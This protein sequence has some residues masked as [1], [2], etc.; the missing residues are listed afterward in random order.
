[1]KQKHILL[2]LGAFVLLGLTSCKNKDLFNKEIYDEMV[3]FK[4]MVDN[5]DRSHDWQ[6][7]K[8]SSVIV[9]AP[10]NVSRLQVLTADP[11]S[12]PKA[13]IAAEVGC[14]DGQATL[15]YSIPTITDMLYLAALASDGTHL[16][17]VPFQYDTQ[18]IDLR[19]V[20]LQN[21]GQLRT[22]SP[23]TFSYLYEATF[24]EPGDFDYNDLVLRISKHYTSDPT[25]VLLTVKVDAVGIQKQVA[26]AIQLAGFR[27]EDVT[28]VSI[29]E[30][31]IMDKNYPLPRRYINSDLQLMRGRSGQAVI[32]LFEDAHWVMNKEKE[33]DGS[34]YRRVL[35]TSKIETENYS[36]FA[37]PVTATFC[38]NF[39]SAE[40]AQKLTFDKM[41]PF[42][43]EEY[44]GG[45]WEVHT[46]AHKF[47]EVLKDIYHGQASAY[48]NHVSWCLTIPK[49]DFRY[50]I[51]NMSLG[52]YNSDTK[53][54]FGPYE[55]FA[56]WIQDHTSYLDWYLNPTIPQQLY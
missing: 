30:G 35:N 18:E 27:Y 45:L 53:A 21:S 6:L 40:L 39:K 38:I 20:A 25:L 28:S 50:P 29:L 17:V 22:I 44:N 47:D 10:D 5:M 11:Y 8:N 32:S 13:E 54:V 26:A 16:G 48:D 4:F 41:D 3:D 23:Q 19:G 24:P 46:Y 12:S 1:M 36:S 49:S 42:I 51:E 2:T 34:I 37:D 14:V 7:I 33:S 31:D 52:T 43:I 55:N 15:N 9:K 56:R